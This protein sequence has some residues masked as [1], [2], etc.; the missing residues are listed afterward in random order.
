MIEKVEPDKL[1]NYIRKVGQA[2]GDV[3]INILQSHYKFLYSLGTD[4]GQDLL[5]HKWKKYCE[6][7][8]KVVLGTITEE[9]KAEI[10][11]HFE[12]LKEWGTK[13]NK[14]YETVTRVNTTN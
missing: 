3:T 11:V 5:K 1:L 6:L 2:N 14:Y 13:I 8:N 12:D 7:L 4:V 10:K 9:E